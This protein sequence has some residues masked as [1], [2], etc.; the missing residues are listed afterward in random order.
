MREILNNHAAERLINF[1]TDNFVPLFFVNR[2]D[3]LLKSHD[4]VL[5]IKDH[6]ISSEIVPCALSII[7][8]KSTT[9]DCLGY[10]RQMHDQH[11]VQMQPSEWITSPDWNESYKIFESVISESV[12]RKD[13]IPLQDATK[14]A[15]KAF[16]AQLL[17]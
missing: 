3:Q 6:I 14:V 15:R 13:N 5:E 4:H 16:S 17:K 9:L 7:D 10:I 12:S 2:T 1:L 11:Y 8:G